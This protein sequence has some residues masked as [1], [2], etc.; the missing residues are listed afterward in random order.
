MNA[1]MLCNYRVGVAVRGSI[2]A[3]KQDDCESVY[4]KTFGFGIVEEFLEIS[5]LVCP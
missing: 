3:C 4:F 5:Q 1:F 2:I